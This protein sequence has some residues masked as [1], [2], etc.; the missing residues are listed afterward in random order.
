M[1][2]S[3]SHALFACVVDRRKR[4]RRLC[5]RRTA[6]W[7]GLLVQRGARARLQLIQGP[8]CGEGC[9]GGRAPSHATPLPSYQAGVILA[10][11]TSLAVIFR[12]NL[13]KAHIMNTIKAL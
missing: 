5:G 12:S 2:G 10:S 6:A 3:A 9:T 13:F 1:L 11:L 4:A 7:G 8:S